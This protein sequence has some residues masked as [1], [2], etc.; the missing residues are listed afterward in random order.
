M[1]IP[2]QI[3]EIQEKVKTALLLFDMELVS[4]SRYRTRIKTIDGI[5]IS[6][7]VHE[8]SESFSIMNE[9]DY[10]PLQLDFTRHE[11]RVIYAH[12]KRLREQRKNETDVYIRKIAKQL[13]ESINEK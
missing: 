1:T 7:C 2:Q 12:L 4:K 13:L 9:E 3:A 5:V 6:F 11:Q 8:L 10:F